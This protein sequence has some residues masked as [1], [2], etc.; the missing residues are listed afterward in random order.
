MLTLP[1]S[2]ASLLLSS[3][4]LL[5]IVTGCGTPGEPISTASSQPAADRAHALKGDA[6]RDALNDKTH[7]GLFGGLPFQAYFSPD[8][9]V[10]A[11][12]AEDA[13]LG[14]WSLQGDD[15]FCIDWSSP[16]IPRGCSWIV[17]DGRGEGGT[18]KEEDGTLRHT[19]KIVSGRQR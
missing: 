10:E 5:L 14:R 7:V 11:T 2:E 13:L 12:V 17:V 8:G 1:W 9:A 4:A 3:C 15:T 19:T 6:L 18:Y 16:P